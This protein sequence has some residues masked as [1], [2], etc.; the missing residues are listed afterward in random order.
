MSESSLFTLFVFINILLSA[1]CLTYHWLAKVSDI[2][3]VKYKNS[4]TSKKVTE[5][6]KL[7]RIE[8]TESKEKSLNFDFY[9]QTRGRFN[10][11]VC[12]S[13]TLAENTKQYNN[14]DFSHK[15]NDY[16]PSKYAYIIQIKKELKKKIN[17]LQ[18]TKNMYLIYAV[19]NGKE[20]YIYDEKISTLLKIKKNSEFSS[21]Y[22][23]VEE[24]HS[25]ELKRKYLK[26]FK[27]AN[28]KKKKFNS[29]F[30]IYSKDRNDHYIA[31]LHVDNNLITNNR[32]VI[33]W[34][35][36]RIFDKKYTVREPSY[37]PSFPIGIVL[38]SGG[39]VVT[40]LAL[41]ADVVVTSY[42]IVMLIFNP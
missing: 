38:I 28:W 3:L 4:D 25:E 26:R 32:F 8:Y 31:F 17:Q 20:V 2:P 14:L 41:V 19:K 12:Y 36:Q 34:P 11:E 10:N 9:T 13:L 21:H 40:P 22:C 42:F 23:F 5:P 1:N 37:F 33:E 15:C 29:I 24:I 6:L 27:S 16:Y 35:Y 7:K 39:L 30:D 18:I